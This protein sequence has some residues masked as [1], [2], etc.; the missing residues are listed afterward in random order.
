MSKEPIAMPM[1]GDEYFPT[2]AEARRDRERADDPINWVNCDACD[3]AGVVCDGHPN[4]PDAGEAICHECDGS[5]GHEW[6]CSE[7]G[8]IIRDDDGECAS[9]AFAGALPADG[10][11]HAFLAKGLAALLDQAMI[12]REKRQ[13]REL[14]I[15]SIK[16]SIRSGFAE[17]IEFAA[18]YAERNLSGHAPGAVAEAKITLSR[19]IRGKVI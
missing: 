16:A 9:C 14:E 17:M 6:E 12:S 2:A 15:A 19:A 7:C 4:D 13:E 5:G 10:F 1:I 3:G 11:D 18:L 8:C